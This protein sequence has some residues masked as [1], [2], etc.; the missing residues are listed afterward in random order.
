M[1]PYL[2][3]VLEISRSLKK[4]FIMHASRRKYLGFVFTVSV[5]FLFNLSLLSITKIKTRPYPGYPEFLLIL[6]RTAPALP[7]YKILTLNNISV[8]GLGR[9]PRGGPCRRRFLD[10]LCPALDD[11]TVAESIRGG[12][13]GEDSDQHQAAVSG[14]HRHHIGFGAVA[15]PKRQWQSRDA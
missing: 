13:F 6:Y 3:E 11:G 7:M 1:N 14:I 2:T 15:P 12:T 4:R 9:L 10:D 5:I 8:K